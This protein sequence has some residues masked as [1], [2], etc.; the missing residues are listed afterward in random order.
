MAAGTFCSDAK[1]GDV[2]SELTRRGY[3]LSESTSAS[4]LWRN[5]KAIPWD[6]LSEDQVVNHLY[7][8][9]RL[10]HKATLAGL[11]TKKDFFP[12]TYDLRCHRQAEAFLR[13]EAQRFGRSL[14]RQALLEEGDDPD[15]SRVLD[16]CE[17]Q[18][19]DWAFLFQIEKLTMPDDLR[20]R[21]MRAVAMTAVNEEGT[22]VLKPAG[23]S[24]GAGVVCLRSM[25]RLVDLARQARWKVVVQAYIERPFLG[26]GRK[27][28][29]IR[30]WLLLTDTRLYGYDRCYARF[31]SVPWSLTNLQDSYAHLCNYSIQKDSTR[32][33]EEE[34][35]SALDDD[36][37]DDPAA[38]G[39][40]WRDTE[41][42]AFI[43]NVQPGAFDAVIRPQLRQIAVHVAEVARKAGL[44]RI[45]NGFEWLG[46]D[47]ILDDDLRLWLLE[48]NV[49]PDVSHSTKITGDLVPGATRD[50]IDIVLNHH[51]HSTTTNH[52]ILW[53]EDSSDDHI[54]DGGPYR[55]PPCGIVDAFWDDLEAKFF[56]ESTT[57]DT[58]DDEL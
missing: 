29:D 27:K 21:A 38:Q 32:S 43:D 58:H 19:D 57:P 10:S 20:D 39:N 11:W 55:A 44:K 35:S 34:E 12:P 41:L 50:A 30:Q 18:T 40:M 15:V 9:E 4:V 5:L 8:A 13:H 1:F 47:L 23:G 45:A 25:R 26:F 31:A 14:L 2:I 48:I 3:Q 17:G 28:F 49:S 56:G 6:T 22:Y 46:I 42:G 54:D 52:W 24:C 7:G 33:E 53:W 36:D 51:H 37:D 16:V